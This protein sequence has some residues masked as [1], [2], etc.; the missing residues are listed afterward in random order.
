MKKYQD[1]MESVYECKVDEIGSDKDQEKKLRVLGQMIS[2]VEAGLRYEPDP[3]HVE[4]VIK[5]LGLD[6]AKPVATPLSSCQ[7]NRQGRIGSQ[8]A[9]AARGAHREG[10]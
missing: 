4:A 2:Y 9:A 6:K 3:R 8:D 10:E 5:E 7:A 1:L